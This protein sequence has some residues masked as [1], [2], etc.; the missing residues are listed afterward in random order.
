MIFSLF[1][2]LK[3]KSTNVPTFPTYE[4]IFKKKNYK[5]VDLSRVH[6]HMDRKKTITEESEKCVYQ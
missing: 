6:T 5:L 3:Q 1:N 2:Y 4:L